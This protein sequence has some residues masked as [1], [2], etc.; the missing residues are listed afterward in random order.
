MRFQSQTAAASNS[1]TGPPAVRPAPSESGGPQ[2]PAE[3]Q[4]VEVR[5]YEGELIGRLP[6]DRAKELL[7]GGLAD[8][9]PRYLR[10]KLGIRWMPPQLDKP[11]GRPDLEQMQRREPERYDDFWRGKRDARIG[12]GALGRCLIDG[13]LRIGPTGQPPQKT[14]SR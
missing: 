7:D 5:T 11:S 6:R 10:L 13:N 1:A 4:R 3:G 8:E 2:A 9:L 14:K 12:K